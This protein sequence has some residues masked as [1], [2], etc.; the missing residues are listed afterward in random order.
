MKAAISH[1]GYWRPENISLIKSLVSAVFLKALSLALVMLVAVLLARRLGPTEYGRL[2]YVQSVAFIIASICTL[3]LR[4]AANRIVA[5]YVARYRRK[6]LARFILFGIVIIA[7]ASC[8][9]VP[10]VY[11]I[12]LEASSTFEAY[13]FPLITI[14]GI[15]ISLALLSFL[16]PALVAMGRPVLSFA[17]ENV[18]PRLPLLVVLLACTI[19]GAPLTAESALD[20]TILGNIVPAV[21]LAAFIFVPS[22]LLIGVLKRPYHLVRTGKA[23]LSISLFMM[24]S[25]VISMVFSETSMIVLGAY[26][27]PAEVAF[28]QVARRVSELAI[29]CGAVAIYIALPKIARYYTLR[30]YDRL[31]H[32]VDIANI[33]TII[34]SISVTLIL[35]LGGDKLLLVFGPD[36]SGAYAATLILTIGRTVDQLF[37]PALEILFMTGQQVTATWI[38]VVYGVLSISLSF[39]LIPHYG[40]IGAAFATVSVGIVW[41]LN[42]YLIVR[43]RSGVQPCLPIALA[44]RGQY[45]FSVRGTS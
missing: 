13:R 39:A 38:N 21:L 41:K 34:P 35:I 30:Q 18:G 9:V 16:G 29:V 45:G 4:D 44:S 26:A 23:W 36:F 12:L 31:Q 20:F 15:V 43:Q 37:G 7:V 17:L 27:E 22:Q 25:P 33:L 14:F 1:S 6:L 42:L 5:R 11:F 8:I 2:V 10:V 3:G 40:Q 28:Y 24:T 32:T 19:A